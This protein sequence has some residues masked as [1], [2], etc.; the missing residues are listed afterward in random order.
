MPTWRTP[1][2]FV[3]TYTGNPIGTGPF[4]VKSWQVG[5]ESQ[6]VKNKSY[7]RHDAAH[8]KL[9]YL[10]GINF[11][12]IVDNAG[13]N[14]ALQTGSVDMILQQNGVQI[15]QLKK[16]KN[17]NARLGETDPLDPSVNCLI[18]NTSATLNQYFCWGE[19]IQFH[20]H[21]RITVVH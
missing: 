10:N 8:R 15:N 1:D 17:V 9:P 16:M 20:W 12:T 14:S 13:R 18:L 6:F 2:S 3:G 11:R 19:R 7:W 4:V 21:S 5:V